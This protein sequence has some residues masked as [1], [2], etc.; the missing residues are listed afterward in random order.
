MDR[1]RI[2]VMFENT[3]SNDRVSSKKSE[4]TMLS[5]DVDSL[6]INCVKH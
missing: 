1:G 3:R 6:R 5:L 2:C 4:D